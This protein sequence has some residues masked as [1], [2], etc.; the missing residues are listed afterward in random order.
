M[1]CWTRALGRDSGLLL[2]AVA[3]ALLSACGG[4]SDNGGGGGGGI[5]LPPP[6]P[7]LVRVSAASPFAAGC[8]SVSSSTTLFV[9]SEV[10]PHLAVDPSD[11]ARL[12]GAWQ[13]DRFSNGGSRGL[14]TARSSDGGVT[15]SRTPLPASR[16]A[17]GTVANGGNWDRAS[18]PWVA[19]GADG[20][21]YAIALS[22]EFSGSS[23]TDNAVLVFRSFDGG[24]SWSAATTLITDSAANFNDKEAIA[25]DPVDLSYAYAAWD[26]L[27]ADSRGPAMFAR[28]SDGGTSWD[29]ARVI[30][31]PGVG[32]QTINNIPIVAPDGT[33]YVFFTRILRTGPSAVELMIMISTDHGAT[34]GAPVR[35]AD[36]F[37]GGARD[38][39]NGDP[40]RDGAGLGSIAVGPSGELVVVWQDGRFTG[41]I[42][43]VLM[44][45]SIDDGASW[46]APVLVN[47]VTTREAFTPTVTVRADGHTGVTYFDMRDEVAGDGRLDVAHW[48]ITAPDA[49]TWTET[50]VSQPFDL[51]LAPVARGLFL[52]DYMGL[53]TSGNSFLPFFVQTTNGGTSNRND[54][55]MLPVG[56]ITTAGS[57]PVASPTKPIAAAPVTPELR[58]RNYDAVMRTLAG[59]IPDWTDRQRA[60][61]A[62]AEAAN[63]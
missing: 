35:I 3:A 53:A 36:N 38:P 43:A 55:Y 62:A 17:G 10:E 2:F 39:N 47:S 16:C 50:R 22:F 19:F 29:A 14:V 56:Q 46:S 31:D 42:D 5:S 4:G 12:L 20:R 61:E 7:P 27:T 15:W 63:R 57:K 9:N 59:R 21:A 52:G 1:R 41:A 48:I 51:Q 37:A 6:G 60:F 23:S 13:Q 33:L 49:A 25:A 45:R 26:R 30:Y 34:F 44:S 40:I 32:N 24:G 8:T 28:T 58:Q 54:V 18:D 11:P